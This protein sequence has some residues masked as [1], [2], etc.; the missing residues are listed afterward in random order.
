M[1]LHRW[2]AVGLAA[3]AAG[4]T[5]PWAVE[6][7]AAPDTDLPGKKSFVWKGGEFNTPAAM[8][9]ELAAVVEPRVRQAVVDELL[10]KGFVESGDAAAADM[11]VSFQVSA[12]APLRTVGGAARRRA[13]AEQRADGGRHATPPASELPRERT[14]REGTVVVFVEDPASGRIVWRGLVNVRDARDLVAR[15]ASARSST[16]RGSIAQEFPA[17]AH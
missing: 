17:Q 14:V 6:S 8:E 9:P 7:F 5:T 1:N 12:D 15:R 10:R 13:V 3:L 16:W 4:C 2:L 11:L